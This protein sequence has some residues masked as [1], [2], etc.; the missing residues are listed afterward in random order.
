VR[1]WY[2]GNRILT[3]CKDCNAHRLHQIDISEMSLAYHQ[4]YDLDS[5]RGCEQIC[6][7][8]VVGC[9]IAINILEACLDRAERFHVGAEGAKEACSQC[10]PPG[11]CGGV[12][13]YCKGMRSL[14]D[15]PFTGRG[16]TNGG[17]RCV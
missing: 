15:G 10:T 4:W 7:L 13:E 11:H 5:G 12:V 2:V 6:S 16:V 1:L 14:V 8:H 17:R 3:V 9:N